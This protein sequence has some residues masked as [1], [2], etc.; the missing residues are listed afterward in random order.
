MPD[1]RVVLVEDNKL[2]RDTLELLL[3]LREG[4]EVVGS[5]AGG[6]EAVLVCGEA[7]PDVVVIDYRMPG[8]DG[9]QATRAILRAAPETR[10]ICLTASVTGEERGLVLQAGAIACLTKD[11]GLDR[12]VDSILAVGMGALP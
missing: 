1:V 10:V 12:I 11:E 4:I 2:F 9:A 5:V 8:L 3:G 7:R 6:A